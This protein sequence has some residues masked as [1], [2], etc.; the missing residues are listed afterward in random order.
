[1]NKLT[2][3]LSVFV[4]AGAVGASVAGIAGCAKKDDGN[5]GGHTHNYTWVDDNN[6]KCHEHCSVD[7]CDA[8]DKPAQDHVW[9]DDNECDHCG[10]TKPNTEDPEGE[11]APATA[12]GIVTEWE[13]GLADITLSETNKTAAIDLSKVKVYYAAGSTKLEKE[14]PA[15]NYEIT[16]NKGGSAITELTG[17]KQG[18]YEI[19]VETKNV[20]N[21]A[22][23]AVT[24]ENFDEL[25]ILNP[26]KANSLVVKDGTLTQV[27]G[28]ETIKSTWTYEVTRANGDKEDVAAANVTVTGLD[29]MTAGEK[30]ATLSCTI[31]GATVTGTVQYTITENTSMVNQ[32]YAI[33]F[34]YLT[35]E[36]ETS[37]KNGELVKVDDHFS[38]ISKNKGEVASENKTV[39]TK[40]FAKRL[41]WNG[42]STKADARYVQITTQGAGTITVYAN[43]A[44]ST[45]DRYLS[46]YSQIT[47]AGI[48]VAESLVK[49][50]SGV[51][52][53][54]DPLKKADGIQTIVFT[55]P[56]AGTY[57]LCCEVNGL[58]INYVELSQNVTKAEGV[59]TV[60]LGGTVV[61]SSVT[62]T[63]SGGSSAHV[64][65]GA[66]FESIKSDYTV[67]MRGVNNV[68]CESQEVDVTSD[69]KVTFEVPE[70]FETAIGEKTITVKYDNTLSST[71]KVY[72]ESQVPGIYGMTSALNGELSTQVPA[73]AKFT[74]KKS[75]IINT[76]LGT[77][78]NAEAQVTAY[79]VTY[80]GVEIDDATGMEFDISSESYTVEISATVSD[81]TNSDTLTATVEFTVSARSTAPTQ[82]FV[83]TAVPTDAN[84]AAG[85]TITEN[86]LFKAVS[87]GAMEYF[88][89]TGKGVKAKLQDA[90]TD[91]DLTTAIRTAKS[92]AVTSP[93]TSITITAN[94]K[95][96]L[97][98]LALTCNDGYSSNK[99][100]KLHYAVGDGDATSVACGSARTTPTAVE[101][102]LEAGQTLTLNATGDS[103]T[104]R[105][106]LFGI[107]AKQVTE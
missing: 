98:L 62:A 27:A 94:E 6:G 103:E 79:T 20:K 106:Y 82:S 100:G 38:V 102:T 5:N 8:P 55:L 63:Y 13:G 78:D 71:I 66:T 89:V 91:T 58:N 74:L 83:P 39:G 64:T 47:D 51:E 57:Y 86:N 21:S 23:T 80:N 73:G 93:T 30:T 7:G 92:S 59:D 11:V 48:P 12:D 15:A 40:Y 50:G 88:D 69:A 17:L 61:P 3:L 72:V 9:G 19:I 24:W 97:R 1:M 4:I 70:D 68:T 41:K 10:A 16:V 18:H 87:T 95:I 56:A 22:G 28:V 45:D 46:V 33:N 53:K 90:T 34:S 77:S 101:V 105:L 52:Q 2:K 99:S 107:E 44:G 104:V 81:G 54:C 29:T 32:K 35:T 96:T 49:D 84:V 42:A 67:K 26:V 36:Q 43:N 37:I 75:D 25:E 14:V 60:E 85:A 76:L 65:K 31:D